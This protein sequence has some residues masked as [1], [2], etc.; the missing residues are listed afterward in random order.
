MLNETARRCEP[1]ALERALPA[2]EPKSESDSGSV[3]RM[4]S[5]EKLCKSAEIFECVLA[6]TIGI[7]M[8]HI[9]AYIAYFL[10]L[11][12]EFRSIDFERQ[13]LP[14]RRILKQPDVFAE[15][16]IGHVIDGPVVIGGVAR[17]GKFCWAE[18]RRNQ[19][20]DSVFNIAE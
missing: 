17:R 8:Q 5:A 7:K 20:S 18:M 16:E 10:E 13:L 14:L 1:T 4:Q 9:V 15:R 12:N 6:H 11:L 2:A 19:Q 3:D